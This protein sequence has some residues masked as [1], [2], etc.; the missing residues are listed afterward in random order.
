LCESALQLTERFPAILANCRSVQLPARFCDV[1]PGEQR[2]GGADQ[3]PLDSKSKSEP[4]M[5]LF[6]F[7]MHSQPLKGQEAE[8]Y[9]EDRV[10]RLKDASSTNAKEA[11]DT[12]SQYDSEIRKC[13]E[14]RARLKDCFSRSQQIASSVIVDQQCLADAQSELEQACSLIAAVLLSV[15]VASNVMR[16]AQSLKENGIISKFD[17][18]GHAYHQFMK[19]KNELEIFDRGPECLEAFMTEVRQRR[20]CVPPPTPK[21]FPSICTPFIR[22]EFM[23]SPGTTDASPPS[24]K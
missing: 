21:I 3:L 7:F 4:S 6:K 22:I 16:R 1:W 18:K 24:K 5:S 12:R 15:R 9:W 19:W 13:E 14:S 2:D 23:L 20:A 10:A 17:S 8:R 11:R